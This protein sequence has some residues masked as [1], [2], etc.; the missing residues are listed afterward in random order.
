MKEAVVEEVARVEPIRTT[1][2]RAVLPYLPPPLVRTVRQADQILG[3]H[4]GDEPSVTILGSLLFAFVL[5]YFLKSASFS[6]RAV[7]DEEEEALAKSLQQKSFSKTVLLV[8][9][10]RAGKTRLFYKLCH[11]AIGVRTAI[12]LRPNVGFK[13]VTR[14][15]DYPGH[16]A[17][18]ALPSD[19]LS[20]SSRILLLLDATQPA[21][22]AAEIFLQLLLATSQKPTVLVLCHQS[23]KAG[24]KNS[25]RL[26][27]QLRTE[28]ERL[29]Q[30]THSDAKLQ[31]WN[32]AE[33]LELEQVAHLAF[34]STSVVS[35]TGMNDVQR[36]AEEGI[37]PQPV[38]S[39][40]R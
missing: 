16:A 31:G 2:R 24:A 8:G 11:N 12:S 23:D 22:S 25:K 39:I 9:P 30:T 18:S 20:S 37:L 3:P 4:I 29:L 32:P 35:A 28:M 34:V 10:P 7:V 13:G 36:F 19:V 27:L 6:G 38:D 40:K 26:R 14:Y 21:A 1:I 15:M 5:Y 17:L 33:P